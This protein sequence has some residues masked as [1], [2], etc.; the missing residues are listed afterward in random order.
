MLAAPTRHRPQ[1]APPPRGPDYVLTL[2]NGA[3]GLLP[4]SDIAPHLREWTRQVE[5]GAPLFDAGSLASELRPSSTS[6]TSGENRTF[7]Q[8]YLPGAQ[9]PPPTSTPSSTCSGER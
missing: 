4:K 3:V 6:S 2:L 5:Q 8:A 7:D 1:P 9:L